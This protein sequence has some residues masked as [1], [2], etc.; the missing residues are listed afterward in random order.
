MLP[1]LNLMALLYGHHMECCDKLSTCGCIHNSH[2]CTERVSMLTKHNQ[3]ILDLVHRY[4]SL[5]ARLDVSVSSSSLQEGDSAVILATDRYN[6][7]VLKELV[8]AGADL[9]LQNEVIIRTGNYD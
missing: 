8:R 2:L 4:R 9:N 6:T 7:P 1:V 3:K 5:N